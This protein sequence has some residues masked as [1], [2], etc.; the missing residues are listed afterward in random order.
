MIND[1]GGINGRRLH[2]ISLDDAYSP[3]RT[4]EQ[5]RKLVEREDV[6]LMFSSVGTA[7]QLAVHRYLNAKRVP[8]L[9]VST[10]ASFWA[11]PGSYPWTM[12]S[13]LIYETEARAFAAHVLRERPNARIAVLY[14]NDD[15][16]R[17]YL[18][19]LREGL[20]ASAGR[21]I[22]AARSYETTAPGVDSEMI[23]LAA[24][25]ADV[26]MNFSVGKFSSQAIRRAH[27][28]GWRPLQFITYNIS[29]IGGVLEPA[30]LDKS[31]G[32][33]TTLVQKIP[34][35]PRWRDD[36]ETRS[37]MEW[38]RRYYPRGDASD[39][40]VVAGYWRSALMIEVLRRAGDDLS[41]EN[42]LRQIATLKDVRVPML[43]P[44][45][46]ITTGPDDYQPLERYQLA[47]FDG[48]S[49]VPFG[50]LQGQ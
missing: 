14:Q 27:D 23:A 2:L 1:Q 29:S 19:A 49:W 6:L 45:V 21:M 50:T 34:T 5:T 36:E 16:G 39:T 41:R 40:Y 31:A 28:T 13:N 30:G 25:G 48:R 15:Y 43:L 37:F 32:I 42:V 10:G 11:D 22:V 38:L 8:Q 44:G 9:L 47:R 12:P 35:D 33:I 24:S 17:E 3:P 18:E 7:C 20:G 4:V 46:S 26:F